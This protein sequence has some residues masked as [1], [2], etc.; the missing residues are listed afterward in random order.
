LLALLACHAG[1]I[2]AGQPVAPVHPVARMVRTAEQGI[3]MR[4]AVDKVKQQTGGR[5]LDA[6]TSNGHYRIKV[7]TP[8]GDVRVYRVDARS[9]AIR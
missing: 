3:S 9:G 5:I 4:E 6:R 7:L 8:A 1:D 2:Y